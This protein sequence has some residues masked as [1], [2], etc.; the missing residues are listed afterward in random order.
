MFRVK[1]GISKS[2][3]FFVEKRTAVTLINNI[4][5]LIESI[6]SDHWKVYKSF[7]KDGFTYLT[8]N[9]M[10][11]FVDPNLGAHANFFPI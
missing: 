7:D 8:V 5:Q 10:V 4:E 6:I 9:R 11:N 2:G 1:N 3:G